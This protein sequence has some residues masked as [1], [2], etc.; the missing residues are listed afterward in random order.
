MTMDVK[1][2]RFI[3]ELC[4][5]RLIAWGNDINYLVLCNKGTKFACSLGSFQKEPYDIASSYIQNRPFGDTT[6]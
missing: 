5:Q 4:V 3:R 6:F 2:A 1:V